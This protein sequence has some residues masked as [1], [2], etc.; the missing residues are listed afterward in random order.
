M[1]NSQFVILLTI[2]ANFELQLFP[3]WLAPNLMTLI[4]FLF[5]L[6]QCAILLYYDPFYESAAKANGIP[7]WVWLYSAF[8][9]FF[10]HSLGKC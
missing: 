10:A 8:A 1:I 3:L 6:S 9:H 2:N 5:L 7:Q 4:G